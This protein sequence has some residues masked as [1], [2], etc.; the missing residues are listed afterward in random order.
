[1]LLIH[2]LQEDWAADLLR[3]EGAEE[4][5]ALGTWEEV[6]KVHS[7]I[8]LKTAKK[9]GEKPLAALAVAEA[10]AAREKAIFYAGGSMFAGL[11]APRGGHFFNA[12]AYIAKKTGASLVSIDRHFPTGSWELHLEHK[13]PLYV[14]YGGADGPTPKYIHKKGHKALGIAVPPGGGDKSLWAALSYVLKAVQDPLVIHLGFDVHKDDATG[15][16]FASGYLY[17]KLGKA[18]SQ[19][20]FYISIECPSSPRVFAES[21]KSLLAGLRGEEIGY[22]PAEESR[23]ALREVETQ[24]RRLKKLQSR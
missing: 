9:L 10:A 20:R 3:R 16:H 2:K 4:V 18:L 1:M 13:F 8:F 17:Y 21:L 11:H 14:I 6:A 15:Y 19:R 23:E 24:I 7:E 12:A 22:Q 5:E